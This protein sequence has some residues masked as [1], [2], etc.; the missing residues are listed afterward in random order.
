MS[1]NTKKQN[2]DTEN[3]QQTDANESR[4]AKHAA[5]EG[6]GTAATSYS[7][8]NR[9]DSTRSNEASDRN[10]TNTGGLGAGGGNSA[11]EIK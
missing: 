3:D 11:G 5:N 10:D 8:R 1:D 9:S 4:A 6:G 2:L 7:D